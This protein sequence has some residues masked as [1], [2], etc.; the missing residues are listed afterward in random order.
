VSD[1]QRLALIARGDGHALDE[2]YRS[3]HR[4]LAKFLRRLAPRSQNID[5]II[6]DT[7]M[8]VWQHAGDFRQSS[9]VSTWIF[10]IAYR[11]ALR[12]LR[13]HKRWRAASTHA[14]PERVT[15]PIQQAEENE[16]L[17]QGLNRLSQ[18]QRLGVVLA[19]HWGHSIQEVAAMTNS[20]QGT[21]K[22]RLFHAR[23]K[24]RVHLN[25]LRGGH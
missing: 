14:Q 23:T 24:L 3:Y 10:G 4:R 6:N 15:N 1:E 19:Y 13:L 25:E 11:V 2:L 18:E 22:A 17:I 21:I 5:E 9:Q 20:P 16:W 12:S 8:V 7:F